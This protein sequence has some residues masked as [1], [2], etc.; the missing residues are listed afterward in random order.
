MNFL[1]PAGA[2]PRDV[3]LAVNELIKTKNGRV[4]TVATLPAATVYDRAWV[5]DAL[6]PTYLATAVG[7][8]SVV[9]PVFYNGH[10]W[11]VA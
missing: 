6:G 2:D 4:Y 9:C 10:A 11:K 1:N 3:S 7:G 5:T 8:G